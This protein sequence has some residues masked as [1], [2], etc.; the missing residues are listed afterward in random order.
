MTLENLSAERS[1]WWLP[2]LAFIGRHWKG[3]SPFW[4]GF[5]GWTL[6]LTL[7]VYVIG[8][9]WLTQWSL[10]DTPTS[11]IMQGV[12][13][14]ALIGGAAIWQLV[15]T[16]RASSVTKAPERW[17]VTRWFARAAAAIVAIIGL[18]MLS[19][20]PKG[21]SSLYQEATDQDWIGQNGYSVTI[22]DE[23][24]V[25]SGYMAWGVLDAV[26]RELAANPGIQMFV[27]NSPGGHVGV[28]TRLYDMVKA[29]GLDTYSTEQCAS[30]C[31]LPYLAGN[32]RYLQQGAKLGFHSVGGEGGNSISAGTAKVLAIY[33][34]S[35]VPEP[36]IERMLATPVESA[37]WP[38]PKEL[39]A[40]NVV[41]EMVK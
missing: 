10:Q 9:L 5:L 4:L 14:F 35:G 19:A 28:G 37:W 29:R 30:A 33:R 27:L 38:S 21:M 31:L 17:W 1:G 25:I 16:W 11:R 3:E 22:E 2:S 7:L 32:N 36:F 23:N 18:L 12:I 13:V 15:G 39:V 40:A 8:M 6:A 26:K 34:A 20:M 41:T 24:L